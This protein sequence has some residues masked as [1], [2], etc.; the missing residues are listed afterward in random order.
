MRGLI[1]RSESGHG[2][3]RALLDLRDKRGGV[4]GSGERIFDLNNF[5]GGKIKVQ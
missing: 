5:A 2:S 3:L 1:A 4:N